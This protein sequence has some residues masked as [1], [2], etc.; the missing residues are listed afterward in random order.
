MTASRVR[1]GAGVGAVHVARE[2]EI[3]THHAEGHT[4]RNIT[5]NVFIKCFARHHRCLSKKVFCKGL[6]MW[7]V[8]LVGPINYETLQ[9]LVSASQTSSSLTASRWAL[10]LIASTAQ[11]ARILFVLYGYSVC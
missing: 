1:G 8:K 11:S 7:S 9:V 5:M 10:V 4:E 6:R 3:C 2:R